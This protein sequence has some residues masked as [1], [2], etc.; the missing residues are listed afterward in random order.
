MRPARRASGTLALA[1]SVVMAGCGGGGGSAAPAASLPASPGA[2]T[3]APSGTA[4]PSGSPAASGVRSPGPGEFLNPVYSRAL[5]DPFVLEDDGTWY[6]YGTKA[7]E[8]NAFETAT[9]T[10]L[11]T[12]ESVPSALRGLPEWSPGKAWAPEVVKTSAGYVMYYTA[13]APELLNPNGD[14]SQCITLAVGDSPAGPLV[15]E[16]DEPLV[17]QPELGGSIDATHFVDTD[18]TPYL[19]WKNDGNCCS[20]PTRFYLQE[21][22]A[23]GLELVGDV[24]ELGIRNDRPWEG[25]V[26]EAPT[27]LER[28]G[29]Y[30]MFYSGGHFSSAGYA[31]G[32]ATAD[33]VRGPYEDSRDNPIL[34]T[35]APAAGPGHQS[36]VADKDGDLWMVYHAWDVQRIGE[37]QGGQRRMWLDELVFED[38]KPVVLGPDAGPQP[39]P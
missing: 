4:G 20:I 22:T 9:S 24:T 10:D 33:N 30:F 29:T 16:S 12:W 34:V 2:G 23:D 1:L 27:L 3:A 26:I 5:A 35:K 39:I 21:L 18:G 11:V 31:V 6:A 32:Y 25:A 37:E 8:A 15:D 13:S 19:I 36:I 14:A 38:G 17:C 7:F 28:D